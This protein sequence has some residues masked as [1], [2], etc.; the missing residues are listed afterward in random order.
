MA[1]FESGDID[2]TPKEFIEECNKFELLKLKILIM[3]M[4]DLEEGCV[5]CGEENVERRSLSQRKFNQAL[6][7]LENSWHSLSKTDGDIIEDIAKK[8]E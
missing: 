3:D 5:D 4:F 2:I 1:R 6:R 7:T 8:Y